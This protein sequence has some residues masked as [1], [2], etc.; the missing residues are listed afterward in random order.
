M[1]IVSDIKIDKSLT[2]ITWDMNTDGAGIR[3]KNDSNEDTDSY[4][5]FST[6]D[7]DNE[8]FKFVQKSC[9][10]GIEEWASIKKDGLRVSGNKVY[11]EGFKPS[12]SDIGALA[13]DVMISD[14]DGYNSSRTMYG[15]TGD[16][17][18]LILTDI[19]AS[20][21]TMIEIRIT[22]NGY[23]SQEPV[24]TN[25]VAYAFAGHGI[26]YTG[27][28]TDGLM[29]DIN[30]F[31]YNGKFAFQFDPTG[32]FQTFRAAVKI[33]NNGQ[34]IIKIDS[35]VGK[36]PATATN[37]VVVTPSRIYSEKHKP[38]PV[39]IGA[40]P[41]VHTHLSIAES[42]L[43][44]NS[45]IAEKGL[46]YSSIYN[47]DFPFACGNA[48]DIKNSYGGQNQIALEWSGSNQGSGKMIIRNKR[49]MCDSW[50]AWDQVY[51]HEYKPTYDEVG[52]APTIHTHNSLIGVDNRGSE[53]APNSRDF[54]FYNDFKRNSA[55]GVTVG[56]SYNGVLTFRPYGTADD[57][58]GGPAHQL[59][60]TTTGQI[61]KR[62]GS[63]DTWEK[64]CTLYDSAFDIEVGEGTKVI[65][66]NDLGIVTKNSAGTANYTLIKGTSTD[67]IE[68]GDNQHL[69]ING[70]MSLKSHEDTDFRIRGNKK[71]TII[72][73]SATGESTN[74]GI[75]D[76]NGNALV[77]GL[78]ID[79][80]NGSISVVNSLGTAEVYTK[81]TIPLFNTA[82]VSTGGILHSVNG[83]TDTD[84]QIRL[85]N[86]SEQGYAQLTGH[87]N[88][89]A[90]DCGLTMSDGE[91]LYIANG[92]GI[93]SKMSDG[94]WKNAISVNANDDL[95]L[96]CG[97]N[98]RSIYANYGQIYINNKTVAV[99][100][101]SNHLWDG[102]QYMVEGQNIVPSKRLSECAN[103]WM[104]AWSNYDGTNGNDWNWDF[105]YIHKNMKQN[106]YYCDILAIDGHDRFC[107][108]AYRFVD[109]AIYGYNENSTPNTSA[110]KVA[111]YV[112]EW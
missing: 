54:G 4:L 62:T 38:T 17:G 19:D 94:S 83:V 68:I 36:I 89:L 81:N 88:W 1:K 2:G 64:W 44:G 27:A 20:L 80:T 74:I 59:S 98:N 71:D 76:L 48:I 96:G 93:Q 63:N 85:H 55:N 106:N 22:G 5:E 58:S 32:Q 41:T 35:Q 108:K 102:V 110:C 77:T 23:G 9:T 16:Q 79:S 90:V 42:T 30:L 24:N 28:T 3:F 47:N 86:A 46:S 82:N 91:M 29:F 70:A 7:D 14:I 109:T 69:H 26:I 99:Q 12:P 65:A 21:C 52:A 97:Q 45:L 92:A 13:S 50:S 95:M 18:I 112:I 37:Q 101:E 49:D 6:R 10:N 11:N 100:P 31:Y 51:T 111:R 67:T 15:V 87:K 103:G 33:A 78:K 39:D 40:A 73:L 25:L 43:D 34:K 61:L 57:F 72:S 53:D 60:F 66:Q 8:Y 56:D 105:T 75:S 107:S 84:W 104:I